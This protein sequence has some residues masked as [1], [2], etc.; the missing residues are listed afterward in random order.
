M[1]RHFF[2]FWFI[3]FGV[4]FHNRLKKQQKICSA[5]N[6]CFAKGKNFNQRKEEWQTVFV[7]IIPQNIYIMLNFIVS[8]GQTS[9][10]SMNIFKCACTVWHTYAHFIHLWQQN[11][12]L[13]FYVTVCRHRLFHSHLY[14]ITSTHP[15]EE[16]STMAHI[17]RHT[18]QKL[19][20]STF[21]NRYDI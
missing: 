11:C 21:I 18:R 7:M 5:F 8:I 14:R 16:R 13:P 12:R 3:Y 2:F 17:N 19:N 6:W 9:M 10:V 4:L 1:R 20:T 15:N